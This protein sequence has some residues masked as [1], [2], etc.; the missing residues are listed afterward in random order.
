[1]YK[2]LQT[3]VILHAKYEKGNIMGTKIITKIKHYSRVYV[4]GVSKTY[5]MSNS[6]KVIRSEHSSISRVWDN[7]GKA[8][9]NS[10][11]TFNESTCK[12]TRK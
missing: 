12:Q 10:M 4:K 2:C 9:S 3:Y 1:M 7:V 5:D 8:L 11:E 6:L